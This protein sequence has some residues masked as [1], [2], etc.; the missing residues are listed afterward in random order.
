MSVNSLSG[1]LSSLLG[2]TA[3][4]SS[5]TNSTPFN[6]SG[7]V[8]GLDTSSIISKLVSIQKA[9]EA[10]FQQQI[11]QIQARDQAYQ[12]IKSKLTGVQT[13][14]Q[15]LMQ[16][17]AINAKSS[18]VTAPSGSTASF[19][20]TANAS[21]V[22]G[23]YTLNV[24]QLASASTLTTN[25]PASHGVNATNP[26]TTSGM[27]STVTSGSFTIN[28]TSISV[29]PPVDS[30]NAIVSRINSSS[31]G[32]TASIVNDA[33]GNPNFIK[34]SPNNAG[35]A[36]QLGAGGDTSNFLSAAGLVAT[37]V[38]GGSVQS[39]APLS[40]QSPGNQLSTQPFNFSGTTT[41]ASSGSFTING[42]TIN[43][44]NTDSLSTVLNRINS[45]QA[46]VNA[47]YNAQTDEVSL[48]N[49]ATG[50]QQISVSEA[51]AP[52]GQSGLLAALGLVG[53]NA[54][55][56]AGKTAQYTIATNGGTPGPTQYSNSNTITSIPGLTFNLTGTGQSTATVGQDTTTA[57]NNVNAFISAYNAAIDTIT[58]D[59]KYDPSS[60]TSSVLTGDT[61]ITDIQAQLQHLVT[62]AAVMPTGSTYGTLGDIGISTGAY[63]SAPGSTSH[64][65]LNSSKLTSA[66][67]NN[68]G[69]VFSVLSGLVGAA[70]ITNASGTPLS[71]GSSWLQSVTGAPLNVS[72]SGRYQITYSPSATVNNL[73]AVF[74][75]G[76]AGQPGGLTGTITPGGG[77]AMIAGMTLTA[78][79]APIGGTEYVNYHVTTSGVLQGVNGYLNNLLEPGGVFDTEQQGAAQQTTDI[80]HQITD[81]N[82]RINQYQQTLQ[83]QFTAMESALATLQQQGASL[84]VQLSSPSSSSRP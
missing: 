44:S 40:E 66:L 15:T 17:S 45:S 80:N 68:A 60:H 16:S 14:L 31:A 22:N 18:S 29:N 8:S 12:D 30:L 70:S 13:A 4:S 48:T 10:Q 82:N 6:F 32:V 25:K 34:L 62:S 42:A 28:G 2:G 24:S 56:T 58:T 11:S 78:K 51:S 50:N 46:G 71:T 64:L 74:T 21:A 72:S 52:P 67:Q 69:A 79:A 23:A 38:I 43:W 37:N 54:V 57:T 39:N 1:A 77:S 36:I 73:T 75:G 47:T 59:T 49:L 84:G 83:T 33:N 55:S 81:M 61:T 7:I 65:V 35:Q 76:G 5:T 19:T 53:P 26:L 63:G 9:P 3:S 41:L 20:A 27:T